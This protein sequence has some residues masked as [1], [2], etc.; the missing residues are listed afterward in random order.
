MFSFARSVKYVLPI[1]QQWQVYRVVT[2]I[3]D[4]NGHRKIDPGPWLKSQNE[5]EYW[6]DYLRTLGYRAEIEKLR[7]D[8]S[9]NHSYR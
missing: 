3:S 9:G 7:G 1:S 5:A 4:P 8:I 6:A 2:Y